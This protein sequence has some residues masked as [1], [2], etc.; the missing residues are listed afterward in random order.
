MPLSPLRAVLVAVL[1]L[2]GM[3][4]AQGMPSDSGRWTVEV[5]P[6][7]VYSTHAGRDFRLDLYL[8]QGSAPDGWPAVVVIRGGSWRAGDKE[9]F[10]TVAAALAERGFAAAS[11]EYRT[12]AEAPF[13]AA[14]H[15]AR[16]A[17]R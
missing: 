3:T 14:L 10:G 5:R 12:S 6:D 4:S 11:I 16:A 1:L 17:V 2:P 15:D 9:G 8:P 7:I 13:P